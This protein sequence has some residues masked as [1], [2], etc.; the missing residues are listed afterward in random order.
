VRQRWLRPRPPHRRHSSGRVSSALNACSSSLLRCAKLSVALAS[1]SS[2]L[3]GRH[4]RRSTV[5]PSGSMSAASRSKAAD[6]P[7]ASS[8]PAE[9]PKASP[10]SLE[11]G[12]VDQCD[13][14]PLC[15]RGFRHRGRGGH[16]SL[17]GD[18]ASAAATAT[19]AVSPPLPEPHRGTPS[20]K[21]AASSAAAAPPG[22]S[23]PRRGALVPQP[24]TAP[25]IDWDA[26]DI[27][28][29]ENGFVWTGHVSAAVPLSATECR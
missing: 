23:A 17:R 28:P 12:S 21:K 24:R 7:K 13:R 18:F 19:S 22:S 2:H 9:K 26:V 27:K 8:P 6:K 29:G 15:V 1:P 3:H 5:A 14:N 16:C 25:R 10:P 20:A 11:D 4:D